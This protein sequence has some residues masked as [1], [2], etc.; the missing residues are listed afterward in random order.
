[1]G[2]GFVPLIWAAGGIF[3]VRPAPIRKR[4]MNED[5]VRRKLESAIRKLCQRDKYLL[6]RDVNER[7]I[8]HRLAMYL[9]AEFP[10]MDVD[11]EYNRRDFDIKRLEFYPTDSR[12]DD[13][14]ARTVYPDIIVHERGA[15]GSNL[16]VIEAK[17]STNSSGF[18]REKLK[19]FKSDPRLH[20]EHAVF[21]QFRTWIDNPGVEPVEFV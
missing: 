12:T 6:E 8:T 10:K 18:D 14:D 11:C 19:A 5:Q 3:P 20:Y 15:Q 9:Q 21:L 13:T 2:I 16:L 17:K 4:A 7:S 1:M